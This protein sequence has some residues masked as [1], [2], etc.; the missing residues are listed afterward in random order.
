MLKRLFV[1][2]GVIVVAA[3]IFVVVGV[4]TPTEVTPWPVKYCHPDECGGGGGGGTCGPSLMD[5]QC[6][7][8][9][10]GDTLCIVKQNY[11]CVP[12]YSLVTSYC[13]PCVAT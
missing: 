2:G 7:G 6:A 13:Q 8:L 12:C 10:G 1:F 5:A 11:C 3:A 4:L 9:T